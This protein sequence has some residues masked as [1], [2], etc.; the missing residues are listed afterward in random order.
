MGNSIRAKALLIDLSGTLHVGSTPTQGAVRALQRLRDAQ[1]PFRFCSNTSQ[2]STQDLREKLLNMGFEVR[3][4][5][6]WTSLG[7]LRDVVKER[8]LMR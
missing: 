2:Q 8:G 7:A 5:E 4:N 6:L 3:E 1:I